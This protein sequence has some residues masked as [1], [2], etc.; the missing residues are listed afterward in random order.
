M[1]T[2]GKRTL[3]FI[4]G[5]GVYLYTKNNKKYLDFGGGIA[6]NSLGHCHPMLVKALKDQITRMWHS[7]NLYYSE[8]QENYAALLCNYSF[9]EKVFFTNSGAESIECGLKVVR[10]Y[11][12]HYKNYE[13]K[14]IITFEGAFHGRTYGALSAQK[15]KKY[16][17]GFGPLLSGFIQVPLNDF[18]FLKKKINE[19]TAAVMIETIQGEGGIR[20]VNL[21][22]LE[23]VKK[24]CEKNKILLFLDEVQS[25][26]GR[27]GKLFS[28]Q[29]SNIEPDVMAVAKGM[30]SGFPIGAC[31]STENSCVGMTRGTHGSTFGGNPLAITVGTS[32][33]NEIMSKDFLKKVKDTSQ[34]LWDQLNNL[35][36]NF[37][38]I[39]EVRGAG[40]LL[41][42]K[43]KSK[44][45]EISKL[46][47]KNGLLTVPAADNIVRLSPPL[48][49]NKQ[50]VDKAIQI[51][52]KTLGTI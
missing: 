25:G 2:Y 21:S 31:L 50:D 24:I 38:E 32:V 43:T 28:Y 39:L 52:K 27:S 47:E 42:I 5:K 17:K 1:P 41:G 45:F 34:Y 11:H 9:A 26:F 48:I 7:S 14:N 8:I 19:K 3:E 44:N 10:S 30:G 22:F 35:K 40:L 46:F 12:Y 29:W 20:P 23:K 36:D 51:I 16:S 49:I 37:D 15:N 18:N 33:I 13:K 6:V 4:Y